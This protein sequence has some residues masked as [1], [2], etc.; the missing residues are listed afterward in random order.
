MYDLHLTSN[1]ANIEQR[2]KSH[3]LVPRSVGEWVTSQDRKRIIS[4]VRFNCSTV[5]LDRSLQ[6]K[7]CDKHKIRTVFQKMKWRLIKLCK[8]MNDLC[9]YLLK[10][11][12]SSLLFLHSIIVARTAWTT[13]SSICVLAF[14]QHSNTVR[15][16]YTS[17]THSTK[18]LFAHFKVKKKC[19][20]VCACLFVFSLSFCCQLINPAVAR[21][22]RV[23]LSSLVIMGQSTWSVLSL[24]W[25]AGNK[26]IKQTNF[27]THHSDHIMGLNVKF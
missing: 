16:Q 14:R 25:D 6:Y 1:Q 7:W 19:Q 11:N 15:H 10:R 13:S 2:K 5:A 21:A 18:L 22:T 4:T 20:F 27:K 8:C 3:W 12:Q 24:L 17:V 26:L 9:D 23:S